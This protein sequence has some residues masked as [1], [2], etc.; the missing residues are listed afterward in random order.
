MPICAVKILNERT[1]GNPNKDREYVRCVTG[2]R[3]G[4]MIPCGEGKCVS[5]AGDIRSRITFFS[6]PELRTE[7]DWR[8][9]APVI[10]FLVGSFSRLI[11]FVLVGWIAR[12]ATFIRVKLA[13]E[14]VASAART[15]LS[16]DVK[17]T[18]ARFRLIR[19]DLDHVD[20]LRAYSERGRGSIP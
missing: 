13:N 1:L 16:Q 17:N 8:V 2:R 20:L 10:E 3:D 15:I 9:E 7:A 6:I 12:P 11:G 14:Q 19:A 4:W 18:T 5:M